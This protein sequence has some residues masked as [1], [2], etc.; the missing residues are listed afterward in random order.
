MIPQKSGPGAR[1][2]NAHRD[3]LMT[4]PVTPDELEW[5]TRIRSAV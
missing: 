4:T 3:G 5:R 2:L 1:A